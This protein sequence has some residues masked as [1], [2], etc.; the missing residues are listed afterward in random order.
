MDQ[1]AKNRRKPVYLLH[2]Y[3]EYGYG[4]RYLIKISWILKHASYDYEY[5][6]RSQIMRPSAA[7]AQLKSFHP[8]VF[9]H[10]LV[11]IRLYYIPQ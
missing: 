6:L 11:N 8:K 1:C 10:W 2:V 5:L 4:K 3:K 7:S 9:D